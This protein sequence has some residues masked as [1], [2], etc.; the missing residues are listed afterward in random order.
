MSKPDSKA[1]RQNPIIESGFYLARLRSATQFV[2]ED[3]RPDY[4]VEVEIDRFGT[5]V[6]G[7]RLK[8]AL[9][10]TEDGKVHVERFL[11]SFRAT[12]DTISEALGRYAAIRVQ[13]A[14]FNEDKYSQVLFMRQS[15]EAQRQC[16]EAEKE[17]LALQHMKAATQRLGGQR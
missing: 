9:Y 1:V 3:D 11:A 2:Q 4:E 15:Q 12:P 10:G 8:A 14:Q 5:E 6:D 16:E 13:D 7:T 17:N